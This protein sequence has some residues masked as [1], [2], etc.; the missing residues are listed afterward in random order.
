MA[1]S[2]QIKDETVH[3]IHDSLLRIVLRSLK[4]GE[5]N[6]IALDESKFDVMTKFVVHIYTAS[7]SQSSEASSDRLA[8]YK[9]YLKGILETIMKSNLEQL[10]PSSLVLPSLLVMTKDICDLYS[11]QFKASPEIITSIKV[12]TDKNLDRFLVE[13]PKN[14]DMT[15]DLMISL[16]HLLPATESSAAWSSI[17]SHFVQRDTVNLKKILKHAS[18]LKTN[19]VFN[20][21]LDHYVI[22]VLES[23]KDSLKQDSELFSLFLNSPGIIFYFLNSRTSFD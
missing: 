11:K 2:S 12:W 4:D 8:A 10:S 14:L 19:L 21:D 7:T 17:L 6:G 16:S 5:W 20:A 15:L 9:I 18:R 3:Y 22:R 13:T 1:Q 23:N